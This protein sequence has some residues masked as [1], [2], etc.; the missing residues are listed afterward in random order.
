MVAMVFGQARTLAGEGEDV[1][2]VEREAVVS[3]WWEVQESGVQEW[4][5]CRECWR[6]GRVRRERGSEATIPLYK[7]LWTLSLSVST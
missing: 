7:K 1:W 5:S 2:G 6:V 4:S 3:G